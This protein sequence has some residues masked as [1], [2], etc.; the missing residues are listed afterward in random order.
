MRSVEANAQTIT[1]FANQQL[2]RLEGN[3]HLIQGL[4]SFSGSIL[5]YDIKK[6]K[7]VAEKAKNGD[8]R[9][10]FKINL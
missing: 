4:D 7:M 8:Q 5:S 3:A 10:K 2:V 1:Y 6:D 9:I